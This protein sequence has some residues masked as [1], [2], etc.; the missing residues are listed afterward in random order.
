MASQASNDT[1]TLK[2]YDISHKELEAQKLHIRKLTSHVMTGIVFEKDTKT[3]FRSRLKPLIKPLIK[4]IQSLYGKDA[5]CKT[6]ANC[7]DDLIARIETIKPLVLS[8]I[9]SALANDPATNDPLEVV[10]CYPGF[11]AICFHRIAH[12]L[13]M[14]NIPLLPRMISELTHEDTGI[15]IHPGA[16]IQSNFFID[17][18][19]GVVIGQTA[20][21][22]RNVTI[23]QGVTLGAKRFERHESGLIIKGKPRHPII[24]DHVTIYAGATVLGRIT[25]GE[26]SI[27]GGNVWITKSVPPHSL[28]SQPPFRIPIDS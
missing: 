22:G 7:V 26:N 10:I 27:I 11:Q 3:Y 28:I 8:D 9:D 15:D 1:N 6:T 14:E 13:Y 20:I 18:G 23:Y 16:Q 25:I 5:I 4:W 17:H 19:T 2:Q 24:E 21:I 12:C